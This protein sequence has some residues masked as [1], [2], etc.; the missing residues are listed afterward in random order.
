M[1]INFL[2]S[3]FKAVIHENKYILYTQI[4]YIFK[5]SPLIKIMSKGYHRQNNSF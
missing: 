5:S 1:F 3:K 4:V 2:V